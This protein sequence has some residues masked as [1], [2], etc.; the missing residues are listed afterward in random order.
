MR[1]HPMCGG[2]GLSA[3]KMCV[4]RHEHVAE[5]RC[6]IEHHLLKGANSG[7]ELD[8]RIHRPETGRGRDLV[9]SAATGVKLRRHIANLVVEHPIDQR[10]Y[11]LVR[12]DRLGT[13]CE[14]LP[15]LS[16]SALDLFAFF[17]RENSRSPEGN[18]PSLR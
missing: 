2:Y 11:V 10:V 18:R 9:I 13:S 16:E 12:G 8:A 7:I 6:V 1:Q 4:R 17:E 5:C 14:L 3:L 15:N